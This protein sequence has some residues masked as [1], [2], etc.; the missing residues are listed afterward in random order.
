MVSFM[1]CVFIQFWCPVLQMYSVLSSMPMKHDQLDLHEYIAA[2]FHN[3]QAKLLGHTGQK[4]LTWYQSW[5]QIV[6][7]QFKFQ[8]TNTFFH[9]I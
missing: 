5:G 6:Q 9:S 2:H 7:I 8:N 1:R 3:S 4:H